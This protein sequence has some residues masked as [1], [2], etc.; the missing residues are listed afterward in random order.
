VSSNN[1]VFHSSQFVF[2]LAGLISFMNLIFWHKNFHSAVMN[3]KF[4][5]S[6]RSLGAPSSKNPSFSVDRFKLENG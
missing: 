5:L 6:V 2:L 1:T 3:V 4:A